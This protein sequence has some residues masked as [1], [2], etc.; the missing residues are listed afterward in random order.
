MENNANQIIDLPYEFNSNKDFCN[1]NEFLISKIIQVNDK[2]YNIKFVSAD[3]RIKKYAR[4]CIMGNFL[5]DLFSNLKGLNFS[6]IYDDMYIKTKNQLKEFQYNTIPKFENGFF[7]M[8]INITNKLIFDEK[9]TEIEDKKSI[10]SLFTIIDKVYNYV[11]TDDTK[12]NIKR[13]IL[14]KKSLQKILDELVEEQECSNNNIIITGGNYK[15]YKSKKYK[16]RK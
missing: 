14:C 2:S 4:I 8:F 9:I 10:V 3:G 13:K 12:I 5:N 1:L 6:E 11:N 16:S 7:Q 15:K